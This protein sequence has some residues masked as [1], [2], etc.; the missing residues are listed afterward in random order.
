MPTELSREHLRAAISRAYGI[1]D[2]YP[3]PA[4]TQ[5]IVSTMQAD[6]ERP[7]WPHAAMRATAAGV[8]AVLGLVVILALLA[9][10][11]SEPVPASGGRSPGPPSSISATT[12]TLSVG[13]SEQAITFDGHHLPANSTADIKVSQGATNT[14]FHAV[15]DAQ[16]DAHAVIANPG[17]KPGFASF[18]V[19]FTPA[20]PGNVAWKCISG[21][22]HVQS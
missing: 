1:P 16:G 6:G 9:I 5:R 17:L 18:A 7:H 12:P 2:D 20:V 3:E 10:P 19:C 14:E 4:V 22:V 8:A 11:R 15:V 21:Q 13:M